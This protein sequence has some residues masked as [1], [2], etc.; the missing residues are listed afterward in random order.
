MGDSVLT[1]LFSLVSIISPLIIFIACCYYISKQVKA[2][3]ILLLIGSGLS[4]VL[5]GFYSLLMPY[6]M[7][8]RNLSMTETTSYYTIAGVISFFSGICFAV[9][10][11]ILISN[12]VNAKKSFPNQFPPNEFK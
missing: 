3:S 8:S 5:T 12:T 11:F 1:S 2:D 9:G 6:F 4:L 10:L 7:Q